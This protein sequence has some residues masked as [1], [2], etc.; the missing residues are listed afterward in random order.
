[1]S[2]VKF[3]SILRSDYA[4]YPVMYDARIS[5][6]RGNFTLKTQLTRYHASMPE[7]ASFWLS[8]CV[9]RKRLRLLCVS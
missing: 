1:M 9:D 7:F 3:F 5:Q 4:A 6:P 2:T 8:Y